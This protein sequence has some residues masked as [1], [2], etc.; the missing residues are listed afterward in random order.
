M[1]I[2]RGGRKNNTLVSAIQNKI[3]HKLFTAENLYWDGDSIEAQAFAFLAIRSLKGM[4]YTYKS[5]TGVK[6]SCSGGVL[7]NIFSN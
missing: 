5:T 3:E 1:I 2:T 7:Y 4:P 6:E